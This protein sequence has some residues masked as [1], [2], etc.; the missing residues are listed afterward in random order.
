MTQ[1]TGRGAK[2][3]TPTSA[4][5]HRS[6]TTVSIRFTTSLRMAASSGHG[7]MK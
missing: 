6:F 2:R 3:E 5:G 4:A 7:D 1:S